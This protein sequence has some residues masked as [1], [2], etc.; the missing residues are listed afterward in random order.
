[1]IQTTKSSGNV[2]ED[3]GFDNAEELQAKASLARHIMLTIKQKKLKQK[4]VETLTG[5]NQGDISKI[6]NG[7]CDRYS[8][9]KLLNILRK[10]GQDIEINTSKSKEACGHISVIE[11]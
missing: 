2:F 10:L 6:I 5:V 9:D 7:H 3:L 8:I 11:A 4:E 1:M